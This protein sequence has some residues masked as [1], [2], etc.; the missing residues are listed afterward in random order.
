M[1]DTKPG[2]SIKSKTMD[3]NKLHTKIFV[4]QTI[5]NEALSSA[6]DC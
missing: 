5:I 2:H 3:F 1:I 6:G 4:N